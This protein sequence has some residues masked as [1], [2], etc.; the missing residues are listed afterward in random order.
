[1]SA[2]KEALIRNRLLE[3]LQ[4]LSAEVRVIVDCPVTFSGQGYAKLATRPD[5]TGSATLIMTTRMG[6][7]AHGCSG[8][9]RT[10][11]DDHGDFTLNQVD[12]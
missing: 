6:R 2:L 7:R 10:A 4:P 12:D 8:C 9:R 3:Q 11:H 1:M 5:L